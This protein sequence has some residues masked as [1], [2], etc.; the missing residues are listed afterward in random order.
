MDRD[1]IKEIEKIFRLSNSSSELFDAFH[2][3]LS[4][5]MSMIELYKTLLANPALNKDEVRM[6]AEKLCV[7]FKQ[8]SYEIFMWTANIFENA[9]TDY[10]AVETAISFYEK[11]SDSDPSNYEPI[12]RLLN[13]YNHDCKTPYNDTVLNAAVDRLGGVRLKSK[14]YFALAGLYKEMGNSKQH[15]KYLSLAEKA[16]RLGG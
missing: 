16:S 14:V 2:F 11:A 13:L 5:R 3:A 6:F 15:I 10:T 7:V 1:Y 8:H 4:N 12:V 9:V